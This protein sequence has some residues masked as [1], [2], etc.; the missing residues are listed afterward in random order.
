MFFSC[1]QMSA[2]LTSSCNRGH[3]TRQ[4]PALKARNHSYRAGCEQRAPDYMRS[5]MLSWQIT[6]RLPALRC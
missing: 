5:E 3:N 4:R 2:V 6:T 1:G